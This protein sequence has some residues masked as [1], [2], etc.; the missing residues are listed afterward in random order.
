[1]KRQ[2]LFIIAGD[3]RSSPRPAEAIRIAAGISSC[4]KVEMIIYLRAEAVRCVGEFAEE[5]VDSENYLRYLPILTEQNNLPVYVQK[6]AP[7]LAEIGQPSVP[8]QE[9]GEVEL[10]DLSAQ[11]AYSVLFA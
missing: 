11:A 5:L 4:K 3:P 7:A 2:F 9:I 1:M 10:A 6:G 8:L